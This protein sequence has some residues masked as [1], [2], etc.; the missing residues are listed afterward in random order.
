VCQSMAESGHDIVDVTSPTILFN[1]SD[2]C[3]RWSYNMTSK[4]A[5]HI[6]L[7]EN[8]VC[9]WI[10]SKLLLVKHVSGKLNPSDIF[11]KEMHDGMHFLQLR[12]SFMSR[13]SDF[14]NASLLAVHH[15]CQSALSSIP[16]AAHAVLAAGPLSYFSAL[17]SSSLC[18]SL[19][20]ISHLSSAGQQLLRSLYG[21]VP[22]DCALCTTPALGKCAFT[23]MD[24]LRPL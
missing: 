4:A 3:V 2:A 23:A 15:V 21:F 20:A 1:N 17:A 16:A 19:P 13:L 12:D 6:E 22:S 5:C 9:E 18:R 8:S 14:V 10:Q 11:T 7:R 24:R